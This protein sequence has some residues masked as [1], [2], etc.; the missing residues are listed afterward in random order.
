M[1][2]FRKIT[3]IKGKTDFILK[4]MGYNSI[5]E[6]KIYVDDI[7]NKNNNEKQ[8]LN[9]LKN[10]Y[11]EILDQLDKTKRALIL[12]TH[13][14][15]ITD[16]NNKKMKNN[17]LK[18]INNLIDNNALEGF[19]N[20][21]KKPIISDFK[22]FKKYNIENKF[23]NPDPEKYPL[24]EGLQLLNNTIG[25]IRN[26]LKQSKGVKIFFNFIFAIK[27]QGM[28]TE[29]GH[30]TKATTIFKN[31]DIIPY[32]DELKTYTK[33][34]IDSFEG[35]GSGLNLL[36]IESFSIHIHKYNPLKIKSYIPL[37]KEILNK[38]CCIN[39]KNEDDKC[40]MY[41]ILYHIFKDKIKENPE[42]PTKY[43]EFKETDIYKTLE[44]LTYPV[45]IK[46]IEKIENLIDYGIN[47]YDCEKRIL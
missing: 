6:A 8:V 33:N 15:K 21:R 23:E 17:F 20:Q 36:Y 37:P 30:T 2:N 1:N 41:C 34:Y 7:T 4:E 18:E 16:K 5:K 26:Q 32:L 3:N 40:F 19:N 10:Q 45:E 38:K 39:I 42:R 27:V 31:E 47:I 46:N 12:K 44:K 13:Q 25:I 35:R 9:F 28:E 29:L 22:Q 24:L 43:K 11:N 14:D